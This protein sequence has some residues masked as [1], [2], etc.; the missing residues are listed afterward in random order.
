MSVVSVGQNV[1][2]TRRREAEML[3]A[4]RRAENRLGEIASPAVGDALCAENRPAINNI[5]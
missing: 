3:S 5:Y 1:T 4:S 2:T